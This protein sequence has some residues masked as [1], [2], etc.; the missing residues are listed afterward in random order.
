MA[1]ITPGT[2][3]AVATFN[4]SLCGVECTSDWD[5]DDDA[6]F[7]YSLDPTEVNCKGCLYMLLTKQDG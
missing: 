4:K 6:E 2:T 7:I 5:E 1:D 3:H